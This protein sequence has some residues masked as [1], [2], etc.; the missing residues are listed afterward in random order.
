LLFDGGFAD[1]K[2]YPTAEAGW[3]RAV[4]AGS[5]SGCFLRKNVNSFIALN[6]FMPRDPSDCNVSVQV[7]FQDACNE[8]KENIY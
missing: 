5:V 1:G 8:F 2:C 3:K 6:S 7:S 4:V